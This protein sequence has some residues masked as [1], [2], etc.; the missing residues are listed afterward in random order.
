MPDEI[1]RNINRYLGVSLR[2]YPAKS[3]ELIVVQVEAL[4]VYAVLK[5]TL[6]S[7]R[8]DPFIKNMLINFKVAQDSPALEIEKQPNVEK[9]D[10]NPGIYSFKINGIRKELVG[11][12]LRLS[13]PKYIQLP[14][15]LY[16]ITYEAI[17]DS[18]LFIAPIPETLIYGYGPVKY[19][20]MRLA[21]LKAA[22]NTFPLTHT[23]WIEAQSIVQSVFHKNIRVNW[24]E[25]IAHKVWD[26]IRE[27]FDFDPSTRFSES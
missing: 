12:S 25:V 2:D 3:V 19:R 1:R 27:D 14:R 20:S 5:S 15:L 16:E 13:S 26:Y 10:L 21:D 6:S 17:K 11:S 23:E 9:K 4:Y 22:V 8:D 18:Q 24:S 7:Q